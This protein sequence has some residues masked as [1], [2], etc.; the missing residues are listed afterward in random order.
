MSQTTDLDI[1]NYTI[2]E[3]INFFKLNEQ[4]TIDDLENKEDEL[5]NSIS[6]VYSNSD[7]SYKN[8]IIQF[9]KNGKQILY[10]T[11]KQS[12]NNNSNRKGKTDE[13]DTID[14]VT[15]HKI[16]S[17]TPSTIQE[18]LDANIIN[19]SDIPSN[20]GKNYNNVGKIINPMTNHPSL[21]TQSISST[22]AN[23]YNIHT[24]KTNY[25]FNTRFR[26]NYFGTVSSNCSFTIP[27]TI[28]N[29][30]S[31]SLSGIQ[32]PNVS[33]TF[34][35]NKETNQLYI[36]EDTTG[37]NAIV[38]IPKGNYV[39]TD[40][41]STLEKSINEQVLGSNPNRFTVTIN[42]QSNTLN[43]INSTYTFRINIIKKKSNV[44][45]IYN[46]DTFEYNYELNINID[47]IDNKKKIKPSDY[48]ST[49]GYLMGFRQ[50]EYFGEKSYTTEAPFD[51]SL[52][53]Y[54]Y[55]ELNDYND[56][57]NDSNN[58]VF[59]T[60]MLS[61]D[62]IAVLPI[63][64]PKY[65]SSFDNNAN[66]VYKTREYNSPVDIRKISIKMLSDQGGLVDLHS[67]DFSFILEAKIIYDNLM[68]Y[69]K[70]DV[71]ID[72]N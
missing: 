8:E 68:P 70:K 58:G 27:S 47:N 26:D 46:C 5:I 28:K 51:D 61:Q 66:F 42:K 20:L 1:N 49:M 33:S 38:E 59:P 3:L 34:S 30:I 32:I 6:S 57:Q 43:I 62:I 64:T 48:F 35:K 9:I 54:Y 39:I 2:G 23:G 16:K 31:I 4:Y 19:R 56:N 44:E 55:F 72:K 11:A 21:Q 24:K 7:I 12:R 36:Y 52:Q 69:N 40:F 65:I 45:N 60:Y 15:N 22:T 25:I 13:N 14:R 17:S 10:G 18:S 67:V 50:I 37:L 29:V 63:T 71:I 41:A 53:D